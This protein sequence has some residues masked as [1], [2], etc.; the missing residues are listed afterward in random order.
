MQRLILYLL[1]CLAFSNAAGQQPIIQKTYVNNLPNY[2]SYFWGLE[3]YNDAAFYIIDINVNQPNHYSKLIKTDSLLNTQWIKEFSNSG[4]RVTDIKKFADDTLL[5]GC[6]YYDA[7]DQ[8]VASILKT[9]TAVNIFQ[10]RSLHIPDQY[11][12]SINI[13]NGDIYFYGTQGIL[14][15]TNDKTNMFIICMDKNFN[16]KW[17]YQMEYLFK[18]D[19]LKIV[20]YPGN[21]IVLQATAL[22]S[23]DTVPTIPPENSIVL[24]IDSVGNLL[25]A[26]R[27]G[28]YSNIPS[29]DDYNIYNGDIKI[30]K[31]GN[32][33]NGV[34]TPM[35]YYAKSSVVLQ[36]LD[37]AGNQLDCKFF[38]HASNQ[39][40]ELYQ[41][42]VRPDG[43]I[44]LSINRL[45]NMLVDSNL[46]VIYRKIMGA[47]PYV[48]L[49]YTQNVLSDNSSVIVGGSNGSHPHAMALLTDSISSIGC[50][51]IFD[52]VFPVQ[53]IS[54]TNE[55]ILN[56]IIISPLSVTDTTMA[57]NFINS[58]DITDSLI[59]LTAT[60]VQQ[61][62]TLKC[63]FY[64]TVVDEALLL[65]CDFD[66][67][68]KIQI[69]NTADQ[70]VINQ[71]TTNR[72]DVSSLTPGIYF[73][74]FINSGIVSQTSKFIKR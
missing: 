24:R 43:N 6:I 3:T 40:D 31:Q 66:I 61:H 63:S 45:I 22:A 41:L 47:I 35:F 1:F 57:F 7:N 64:P 59:C 20:E 33:I 32:I 46:N 25:W 14:Y 28:N 36:K 15:N 72:V 17:K 53:N 8:L 56:E 50:G 52:T 10:A 2:H 27:T 21:G 65:N 44:L 11:S 13:C 70:L 30:D 39:E 19:N 51:N 67:N 68:G 4:I 38:L 48:I 26:Q 49:M 9:D 18:H 60:G 55:D 58:T 5:L 73:I 16:I 42:N 74:R 62:E 54:Y 34:N 71:N 23:Y 37:S 29:L 69:Y 12:Y